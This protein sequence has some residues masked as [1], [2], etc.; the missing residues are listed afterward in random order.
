VARAVYRQSCRAQG[1]FVVMNCAAI[2]ATLM[3]TELF[4]SVAG[5]YTGARDRVGLI[6]SANRGT[7][8]LDEVGEMSFELQSR[9]LRVLQ[10]G[11]FTRVGSTRL[12]RVDMRVIA[13]TNRDLETEVAQGRFRQD[14]YFRLAAVTLKIP[15]LRERAADLMML[16]DHFLRAFAGRW[17]RP[18]PGLNAECV[19]TLLA[20][21]FP[22]NVRELEG[23][24][25]RIVALCTHGEEISA[26]ALSDRIARR[27]PAHDPNLGIQPMSL[28]EMEKRLIVSVLQHAC[29]N[30]TRAAEI[31]GI[32]REGLRTKMQKHGLSSPSASTEDL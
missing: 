17:G 13:A 30:R 8:F 4:G 29:E 3:E 31:L 7:L 9:L 18:T 14:L 11:E 22:G 24:M 1:S 15:P 25:S 20:Y 12:E 2:P 32:S 6:G 28:A 27:S 26:S 10:F 5:A 19:Q 21:P 23:E 16:A